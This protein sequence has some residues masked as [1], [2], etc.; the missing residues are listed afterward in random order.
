MAGP[1]AGTLLRHA[2]PPLQWGRR[3]ADLVEIKRLRLECALLRVLARMFH[4]LF[5]PS[6]ACKVNFDSRALLYDCVTCRQVYLGL[7]QF[8]IGDEEYLVPCRAHFLK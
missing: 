4:G 3:R 7:P 5:D 2:P 8:R 1:T 6:V